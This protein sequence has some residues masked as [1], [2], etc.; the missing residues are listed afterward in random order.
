MENVIKQEKEGSH[1]ERTRQI[2]KSVLL[3]E[4]N[5]PKQARNM[6]GIMLEEYPRLMNELAAMNLSYKAVFNTQL[7]W[8]TN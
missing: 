5:Y 3:G 6:N 1:N 2:A 4:L 7:M 8:S